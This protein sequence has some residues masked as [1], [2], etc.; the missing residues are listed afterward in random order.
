ME[1]VMTKPTF[2]NEDKKVIIPTGGDF[3]P[4][5]LIGEWKAAVLYK[6]WSDT[7][8]S[9]DFLGE[10]KPR[11]SGSGHQYY[12]LD[13]EKAGEA[14][15][16][17]G[18]YNPQTVW[19]FEALTDS[20][21]NFSNEEVKSN[22]GK[23]ISYDLRIVTLRSKKYRHELHMLALPSAVN[24]MARLYGYIKEDDRYDLS[25]LI[26]RD[27]IY[28]DE[29]QSNLVGHPDASE[30]DDDYYEKSLLWKRRMSLWK[31]LGEE[32][33]SVYQLKDS[34]KK[35]STEAE[36]LSKCLEI[37]HLT[38]D[39]PAF[40]RL[41]AVS[42][43]RADAV[44]NDRQLQVPTITDIFPDE[45]TADKVAR[46]EVAAMQDGQSDSGS[47]TSL[48]A[49]WAEMDMSEDD[50]INSLKQAKEDVGD[51]LTPIKAKKIADDLDATVDDVQGWWK[52][53]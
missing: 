26:S 39:K 50:W 6:F 5:G 9:E 35:F 3:I 25:E 17:V 37:L 53:V 48:P 1:V 32:N 36:K 15:N 40:L 24:A 51:N 21:K 45:K 23:T 38:W 13:Y 19:H 16:D 29:L 52:R 46:K 14:A 31:K 2:L 41:V 30:D 34:G 33:A 47:G 20:I 22:F 42:D 8:V 4:S 49:S 7:E 18:A 43:P 28:N 12:F 27:T 11:I 44:Y 10:I